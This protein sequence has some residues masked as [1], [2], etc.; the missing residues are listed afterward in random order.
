MPF[1][2]LT[3]H[4]VTEDGY[5]PSVHIPL[6]VLRGIFLNMVADADPALAAATHDV[7]DIPPYATRLHVVGENI[8]LVVNLFSKQLNDAVKNFILQRDDAHFSIGQVDV[9]LV[10]ISL[11]RVEPGKFLD[12]ARPVSKF[13]L[14]FKSATYFKQRGA[15]VLYPQPD[16]LVHNLAHVWNELVPDFDHI[17]ED[18]IAAWAKLAVRITSYKLQTISTRLGDSGRTLTGFTGW[19]RFKIESQC[20]NENDEYYAKTLDRLFLFAEHANIGGSRTT[21]FG[22]VKYDR[23]Q[24]AEG[25]HDSSVSNSE[26]RVG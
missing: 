16:L 4:F 5:P 11:N 13:R 25:R 24:I 2:T 3:F 22:A 1:N 6:H 12:D 19:A 8:Y 9:M 18:A 23:E 17:D 21:G 10:K 15:I 7:D 14:Q 26:S 20:S